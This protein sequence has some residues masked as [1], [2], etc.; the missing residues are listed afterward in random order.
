MEAK[1]SARINIDG[2]SFR[3]IDQN[4]E[5]SL[6]I[7]TLRYVDEHISE[8]FKRVFYSFTHDIDISKVERPGIVTQFLRHWKDAAG[9]SSI[10]KQLPTV[11]S[12]I[13]TSFIIL[14]VL[15]YMTKLIFS[16]LII[17]V[18]TLNYYLLSL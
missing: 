15:F 5:E 10:P 14:P 18:T 13:H 11:L 7:E 3:L 9:V 1:E 12:G 2:E 8:L 4:L 16:F 17:N 6:D